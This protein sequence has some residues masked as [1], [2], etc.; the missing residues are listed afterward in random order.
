MSEQALLDALADAYGIDSEYCDIWG[1]RHT[2]SLETQRAILVA[3][4][5]PAATEEDLQRELAE[6]RDRPWRAACDP[7]LVVRNN[8]ADVRWS[9]RLPAEEEEE[10]SVRVRWEIRDEGGRLCHKAEGAPSLRPAE[11]RVVDG[12]RHIRLEL[13]LPLG[14]E[15]GYYDLAAYAVTP[16]RFI[17]G[18]LRLIV[19][20][21]Q[22]YVPPS[23]LEGGKTWGLALQLYA[24]RSARNW[25]IGDFSDLAQVVEWAASDLK[26]GIVGLN[27]LHAL[28]N[29]RPYHISPYAPD[30]RFYLNMLYV[31]VEQI[32]DYQES[33]EAR[34]WVEGGAG[35][36]TL[37]ALRA[38]DM[39]DYDGVAAAKQAILE[40]CFA[41]FQEKHF[42]PSH[43]GT[44]PQP[45]TERARAFQRYV[46]EEGEPL[47][48]FALFQ[49]LTEAMRREHPDVW[50]WH[51]WPEGYCDL[52][53]P[54]VAAF[55]ASHPSRI[56]FYKYVQWVVSEQLR[57]V[58]E[59]ARALGMP[60]G[61]FHDLALGSDRSGADAWI[62]QGLFVLGADCGCP[63]DAFSPEG[64][65]WSFP[66]VNPHRLR[67]TGYR[68][69]VDLLRH[70]L[71]FGGALRIDHVMALFRLFWIPRGL[72]ASAGAYVR[73]PVEDLLGILALESIRHQALIVGE[74]LGTVPDEVRDRLGAAC[75]LSYRV[76][77]FERW[78]DGTEKPPSA[79]PAQALAV[80]TTHDLPTLAGFWAG[81]DI[82]AR[83]R[84]GSY[85][86]NTA[87]RGAWEERF[88]DKLR[89]WNA[90]KT[91]HLLP[92]GLPDDL[93]A[94]PV[95]T[96]ELCA[97]IHTYLARTP[98]WVVLAA[99]DDVVG[100]VAQ[101][102][103]P[104]TLD[105]YP[106]WSRKVS[107]ALESL[108]ADPRPKALAS[109]LG[110]LRPLQ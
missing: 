67:E 73:Y 32:P 94:V 6:H 41:S 21:D 15:I 65:N 39:V 110:A 1:H 35:C 36:S 10:S 11:S 69:F 26:A 18:A 98:S 77:Y 64:Q 50:V 85:P 78:D 23:F 24:L 54:A 25:G 42:S 102:N 5:V 57:Q 40:I 9:F 106:N 109:S 29:S 20:P 80:V 38:D 28:K 27:P 70:N 81:Q 79:Y 90:L 14:L 49:V 86:N 96:P 51:E 82:E 104:G 19:V 75:V 43:E 46:R 48:H 60:I 103:L 84:V 91:E 97:A 8:A 37:Q 58:A 17:D 88:R 7:V 45:I 34:Q 101:M 63:P 93:A 83:A 68:M 56:R 61:L 105:E 53:S 47:E 16:K 30:S 108:R 13:P 31:D 100:E 12:R 59:R 92:A 3:M 55:G 2:T 33:V 99:L 72:P 22:C 95:M 62:F 66:P 71:R 44:G 89:I 74:D 4:G 52:K 76:L 87:K 107:I